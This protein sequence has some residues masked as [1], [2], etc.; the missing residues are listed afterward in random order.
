MSQMRQ[1]LIRECP[2]LDAVQRV[3][4]LNSNRYMIL[5][6]ANYIGGHNEYCRWHEACRDVQGSVICIT[7]F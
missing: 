2:K 4:D 7:D 6:L 1:I 3:C 5:L